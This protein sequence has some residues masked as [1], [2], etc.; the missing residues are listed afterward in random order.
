MRARGA[1]RLALWTDT[2][3]ARAHRF[4]E[5]RGYLRH[6]SIRI[7][8]D[9]SNSLEFR[10]ARP[11]RGLV[12]EALDAAAA[13]SAERRLA[14]IL[15]AC[16]AAGASVPFPHPPAPETARGVWREVSTGVATGGR[17]LLAAWV[18][19]ALAGTVQLD[20]ATPQD[21][22]HRAAVAALL[23]DPAFRRRGVGRALMRRAEQAARGVGRRLLTLDTRAGDP[24][25]R[26]CRDLGWR[27]AGR[28]PGY[29]LDGRGRPREGLFLWKA[30]A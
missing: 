20:L 29:A 11:A 2:R 27:E 25:E 18:E 30:L 21:Q 10:Y 16:A 14:E 17:V 3:F 8:D 7:L 9:L 5:R 4:Y 13:A 12:V 26:L 22:P 19:G 28:I 24:A 15:T 23:V 6:G 1:E